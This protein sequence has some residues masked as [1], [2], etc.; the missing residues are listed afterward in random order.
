MRAG[1]TYLLIPLKITLGANMFTNIRPNSFYQTMKIDLLS[2]GFLMIT[3]LSSLA[4][5]TSTRAK[6]IAEPN[7]AITSFKVNIYPQKQNQTSQQEIILLPGL[8]SNGSIWKP[9]AE[10]LSEHQKVHV[11]NIAGF[12]GTTKID[13]QSLAKVKQDL[14]S[15]IKENNLI[16]PSIIGHSL[17][18]FMAFWLASTHPDNIGPIISVDG[19]PF[20]GPIFTRTNETTVESLAPQASQIKDF[21]AQMTSQQLANQARYSINIQAA[22]NTNKEKIIA[23]AAQS[24]PKTVGNMIYALMSTDLRE[25]ISTIKSPALLIGAAG[26]FTE[27]SDR[28]AVKALYQQQLSKLNGAQLVMNNQSRHFIMFDQPQWLAQ[29]ITAFLK[30]ASLSET[31]P[32]QTLGE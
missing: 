6:S 15:Y 22:S 3:I 20:I 1:V 30:Q 10:E 19:L 14:I 21:Y 23:M 27:D 4:I 31:S 32:Q 26:G 29:E 2:F 7:S 28:L 5:S 12:A 16:K 18:G 24:D 17:G 8:M 25:S 9:L 13:E 11:I